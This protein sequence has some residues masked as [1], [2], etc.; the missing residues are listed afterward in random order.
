MSI[1]VGGALS[2]AVELAARLGYDTL[3]AE[4]CR[5]LHMGKKRSAKLAF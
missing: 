2:L 1:D 5:G 3:E 4:P